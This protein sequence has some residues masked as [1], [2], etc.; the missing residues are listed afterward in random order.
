MHILEMGRPTK[1]QEK[2]RKKKERDER[3]LAKKKAASESET[4]EKTVEN[5]ANSLSV[6]NKFIISWELGMR[7]R[8]L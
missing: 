5:V 1:D 3:Y 2:K 6:R 4:T 7:I 8:W